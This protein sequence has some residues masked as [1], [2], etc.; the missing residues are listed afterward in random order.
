ML[1]WT[2][3]CKEKAMTTTQRLCSDGCSRGPDSQ[4]SHAAEAGAPQPA[5]HQQ[6]PLNCF[7]SALFSTAQSALRGPTQLQHT[8]NSSG[9]LQ[10]ML[11]TAQVTHLVPLWL[12]DRTEN[13]SPSEENRSPHSHRAFLRTPLTLPPVSQLA[14]TRPCC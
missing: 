6:S 11:H 8:A 4:L 13:A 12:A 5:V 10:Q 3:E 14:L 1:N 2:L 9:V 7:P